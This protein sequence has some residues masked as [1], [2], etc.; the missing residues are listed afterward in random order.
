MP[1]RHAICCSALLGKCRR[2]S[3]LMSTS[4]SGIENPPP[5]IKILTWRRKVG[6]KKPFKEAPVKAAK[7]KKAAR[8]RPVKKLVAQFIE[9]VEHLA[10][11][12]KE[13]VARRKAR[14]KK[15][16]AAVKNA[17]GI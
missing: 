4:A 9:G 6:E 12:I 2:R 1:Y 5:L 15:R 17:I 7:K 14:R 8:K 10:E 3:V 16:R 11:N 13:G